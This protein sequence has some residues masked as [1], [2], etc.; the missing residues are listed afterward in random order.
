MKMNKISQLLG[1]RN[2][3][4]E[5]CDKISMDFLIERQ[6][7]EID[8]I[9]EFNQVKVLSAMRKNKLSE[10]HFGAASGY[11]YND[12]GRDVL[13]QIYA[14]IFNAELAITRP[15]IVSGTHAISLA[16]FSNLNH[17]DE[18]IFA[19]GTPYDTLQGVVG[20]RK[21][22]G[23][24]VELGVN[25]K[26]INIREN[27]DIDLDAVKASITEKTKI[28]AFQRSRGYAWRRSFGVNE[29]N[30]AIDT[31]KSVN[32]NIICFV[33]NCYGEFCEVSEPNADLLAGSLIKN[34]GGGLA[35]SGGYVV[36]R[37][38]YVENA[39]CRLTA[40][41]LGR[42]VGPSLG[43]A[44][45][46]LQGLFLAPSVVASAIKGAVFAAA[47]FEKLGFKTLPASNV[48]RVDI[49]QA[50]EMKSKNA[51]ITFCKGIQ[52]GAAVDSFASPE[53]CDMPGY[54]CPIIMAAGAFVQGSSIEFSADAPIIEPYIAYLQGGLTWQHAKSGIITAVNELFE[55]GSIEITK[56]AQ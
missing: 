3:V 4:Y 16:L 6:F 15:Q 34:P 41:G 48:K 26:I 7:K 25:V 45:V 46:M 27:G 47:V 51:L 21:T 36:G 14:D 39:A 13:E 8:E 1:V 35:P 12:A 44:G 28:V 17:G 40:P 10:S 38:E 9:A 37:E 56:I 32:D 54:D 23:S 43:L 5:F 2:D 50:I 55:A 53:P 42:E 52:K 30:N 29:L 49:V 18:L 11:G 22:K 19:T 33:D 20:L 31:V 24:L